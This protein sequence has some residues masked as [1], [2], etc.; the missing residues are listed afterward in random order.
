MKSQFLKNSATISARLALVSLCALLLTA[1]QGR[2]LARSIFVNAGAFPGGDG[3][4]ATPYNR[5]TDA[6]IQARTIRHTSSE[7]IIIHVALGTYVGSYD[8]AALRNN[9]DLEILPIILN[10][11]ELALRGET[12]LTEDD[13]GFPTGTQ[14]G[15]ETVIT[16]DR[17]LGL[18]RN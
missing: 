2:A 13:S 5:I 11:S 15:T 8:A 18:C 3:S 16:A 4:A 14:T 1:F 17:P 12:I 10:V 9:P 6:V 7:R